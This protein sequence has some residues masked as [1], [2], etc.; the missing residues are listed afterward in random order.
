[1]CSTVIHARFS[2]MLSPDVLQAHR[3]DLHRRDPDR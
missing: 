3:R 2:T 1:M